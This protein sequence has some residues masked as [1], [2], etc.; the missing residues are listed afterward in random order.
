M[1]TTLKTLL[2]VFSILVLPMLF[3]AL[4]FAFPRVWIGTGVNEFEGTERDIAEAALH[5]AEDEM[6]ETIQE[7][8]VTV[9]HVVNVGECPGPP[10]LDPPDS[11]VGASPEERR[12][13]IKYLKEKART[14]DDPEI[15]RSIKE[16]L[17]VIALN[18]ANAPEI[19]PKEYTRE[20][21]KELPYPVGIPYYSMK[22]ETYT[23]FGIPLDEISRGCED[24]D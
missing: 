13:T 16:S 14:T 8:F 21:Q 5:E 17:E 9:Y 2:L 20:M 7:P 4:A 23:I 19:S 11:L 12:E 24:P 22:V 1:K 18:D 15:R 6:D 3:L 10:L